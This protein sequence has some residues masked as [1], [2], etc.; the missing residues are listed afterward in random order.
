MKDLIRKIED[1][2]LVVLTSWDIPKQFDKTDPV[3]LS[4]AIKLNN[5]MESIV[6]VDSAVPLGLM[7][8]FGDALPFNSSVKTLILDN[9]PNLDEKFD[10]I[11]EI[12]TFNSGIKYLGLARNN[13]SCPH[14]EKLR[15][16]L[17]INLLGSNSPKLCF[18]IYWLHERK[19]L[20][21]QEP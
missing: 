1:N 12:I 19:Q 20:Y 18:V 15:K 5:S 3:N 10:V 6:L 13:L 17:S 9:I 14:I 2:K 21:T 11:R 7:E 16:P 4:N 8:V